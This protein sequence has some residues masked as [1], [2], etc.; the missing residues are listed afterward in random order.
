MTWLIEMDLQLEYG[1]AKLDFFQILEAACSTAFF[2]KFTP[3][4]CCLLLGLDECHPVWTT[5]KAAVFYC[6]TCQKCIAHHQKCLFNEQEDLEQGAKQ[7]KVSSRNFL[8]L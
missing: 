6:P 2:D 4:Q 1:D 5:G 7:Y 3:C 8:V